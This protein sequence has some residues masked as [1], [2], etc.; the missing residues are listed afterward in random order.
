M[1]YKIQ[2]KFINNYVIPS[3][4]CW[5]L[6]SCAIPLAPTGG[7]KDTEA[8]KIKKCFPE[9]MTKNFNSNEI[10]IDFNE[11]IEIN[12]PQKEVIITPP[13]LA[14]PQ[15][16]ARKKSLIIDFRNQKLLPNTTYTIQ[17]G[18]SIKDLNEGNKIKDFQYIFSTGSYI[19]SLTYNG[20]LFDALTHD[21]VPNVKV[22]LYENASDSAIYKIKPL[23]YTRSAADGSF[24]F[25]HLRKGLF[26]V[27]ALDDKNDNYNIDDKEL[28]GFG[29]S[30]VA[31]D[32]AKQ[33]I[34][35]PI[36]TFLPPVA[37]PEIKALSLRPPRYTIRLSGAM[38]TLKAYYKQGNT[39]HL[40]KYTQLAPEKDSIAGWIE[41]RVDTAKLNLRIQLNAS[42]KDTII[43]G[44]APGKRSFQL[45][46]KADVS[47][48]NANLWGSPL[49]F[50]ANLPIN[51]IDNRLSISIDSHL[52]KSKQLHFTDSSYTNFYYTFPIRDE[53]K[54]LQIVVP[55]AC[56]Q[57][58]YG[59]VNKDTFIT[60]MAPPQ[61]K[62]FGFLSVMLALPNDSSAY[63]FQVVNKDKK[64]V[65]EKKFAVNGRIEIPLLENGAYKLRYIRDANK[66]GRWDEG[67][68]FKHQQA[69]EVFYAKDPVNVKANWELT[70]VPFKYIKQ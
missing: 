8:P 69:E 10:K 25:A 61:R 68:L 30:K 9:N 13:L 50:H 23:Y 36:Y 47:A 1:K 19:D 66:N 54:A 18:A 14:F 63:I 57:D 12:D 56:I 70:D 46:L 17:L 67:H 26:D 27:Y 31:S 7:P 3:L 43:K 2:L 39:Y 15:F 29:S 55:S 40:A 22:M 41:N 24:K 64:V 16:K 58:V 44:I 5:L 65:F 62:D 11:Y 51:N 37:M 20:Q 21:G 28:F 38:D 4:I 45:F 49:V 32:T 60:S 35:K 34:V 59:G 6:H 33:L 48:A 53:S 42:M 52:V